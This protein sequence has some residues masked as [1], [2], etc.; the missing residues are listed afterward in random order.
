MC[1]PGF[2]KKDYDRNLQHAFLKDWFAVSCDT[3]NQICNF[4][5]V[6]E[7]TL[8]AYLWPEFTLNQ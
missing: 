7:F 4:L 3:V 6:I 5:A 8:S 2:Y 1:E